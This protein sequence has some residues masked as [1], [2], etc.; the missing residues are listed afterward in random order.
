MLGGNAGEPGKDA[1]R[2][3]NQTLLGQV[4]QL[5]VT[6]LLFLPVF[7]DSDSY[8]SKFLLQKKILD[9][10]LML[11]VESQ[12][13]SISVRCSVR[14]GIMTINGDVVLLVFVYFI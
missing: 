9:H 14:E 2:L 1:N 5:L 7:L 6:V 13:A 8:I 4:H 3:S 11:G 12:W 10:L